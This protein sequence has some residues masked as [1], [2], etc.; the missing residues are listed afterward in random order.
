[1][2]QPWPATE[3]PKRP[4]RKSD[5]RGSSDTLEPMPGLAGGSTA[6]R[7]AAW[8]GESSDDEPPRTTTASA[9]AQRKLRK[10][11]FG[12]AGSALKRARGPETVKEATA[13]S[14][15]KSTCGGKVR[16]PR[17]VPVM[18]R[19]T[20]VCPLCRLVNEDDS[21]GAY[22]Y[23]LE[24]DPRAGEPIIGSSGTVSKRKPTGGHYTE[25]KDRPY[26]THLRKGH[27]FPPKKFKG[28][29]HLAF[30]KKGVGGGGN[31]GNPGGRSQGYGPRPPPRERR[32]HRQW[33]LRFG[34]GF[35]IDLV[36]MKK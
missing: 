20:W 32:E 10:A 25:W 15:L 21:A 4:K 31:P 23:P 5:V 17:P 3:R 27:G 33:R 28:D 16:P 22:C 6:K 29:G 35:Q 36:R 13:R 11:L 26:Q 7:I 19:G 30:S 1:M 18:H 8:R 24:I 14:L 34:S 9:P 12:G 2:D